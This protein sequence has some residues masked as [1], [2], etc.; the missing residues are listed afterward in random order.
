MLEDVEGRR[1]R[2]VTKPE[3]YKAHLWHMSSKAPFG[4]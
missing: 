1:G 3:G 2:R 4:I